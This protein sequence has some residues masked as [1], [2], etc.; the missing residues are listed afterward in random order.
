MNKKLIFI[1]TGFLIIAASGGFYLYKT[2]GMLNPLAGSAP[3]PMPKAVVEFA[4]WKDPMG[5]TLQYPKNLTLNT[6]DEDKDNYAHVEA[7]ASGS[8]ESIVVWAKDNPYDTLADW[9]KKDKTVAGASA[10]DT[11][12]GGQPAKKVMVG[13]DAS[14]GGRIVTAVIYDDMLWLLDGVPGKDDKFNQTYDSM[15]SG[16]KFYPLKTSAASGDT[17]ADSGGGD[18]EVVE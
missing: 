5:F 8:A 1:I 11:T 12:W 9:L 2:Q 10:L 3:T 13:G 16:F 14:G 7:A 17:A 4:V 15:L 18:E 6:H